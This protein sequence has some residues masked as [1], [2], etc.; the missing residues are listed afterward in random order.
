MVTLHK[1]LLFKVTLHNIG[2]VT[3]SFLLGHFLLVFY[4]PV[5][6]KKN[7]GCHT[8]ISHNVPLSA[9]IKGQ[10]GGVLRMIPLS[11]I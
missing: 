8:V 6:C 2:W 9:R 1:S 11:A 3:R 10:C 7:T 4:G 5:S